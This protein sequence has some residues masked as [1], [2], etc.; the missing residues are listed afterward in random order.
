MCVC[1]FLHTH[2]HISLNLVIKKVFAFYNEYLFFNIILVF[3]AA[4]NSEVNI[5]E[6]FTVK[7]SD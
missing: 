2:T 6:H 5:S 3:V 1:V 7:I 4:L